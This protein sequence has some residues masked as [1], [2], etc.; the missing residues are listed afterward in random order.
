MDDSVL[1]KDDLIGVD[2]ITI[3]IGSTHTKRSRPWQ[4]HISS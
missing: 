1:S 2:P 4:V 3:V